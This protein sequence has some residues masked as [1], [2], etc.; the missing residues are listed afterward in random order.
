MKK[1]IQPACKIYKV[2]TPHILNVSNL[3]DAPASTSYEVLS[4]GNNFVDEEEEDVDGFW[5]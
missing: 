3:G 4:R 5:K 2:S 1:Y